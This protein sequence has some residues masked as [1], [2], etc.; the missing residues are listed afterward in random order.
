MKKVFL[1]TLLVLLGLF[2]ANVQAQ[3][4]YEDFEGGVSDL[5]WAAPPGN[6]TYNGVI[7]NPG[8]D[9]VNGSGFVGSSYC[10]SRCTSRFS[11][12]DIATAVQF[13]AST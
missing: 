11:E 6:G 12:S 5:A 10:R 2:G 9:A 7:A 4:I 1:S 8:P 13:A 3:I